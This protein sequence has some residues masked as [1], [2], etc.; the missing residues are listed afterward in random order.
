MAQ[1]HTRNLE[2]YELFRRG[3]SALLTRQRADNEAARDLFRR[4]I[5]IDGAFARAYA[6]LALTHAADFR[7]QWSGDGAASLAPVD[8]AVGWG[9][10]SDTRIVNLIEFSQMGRFFYWRPKEF[11]TVPVTPEILISHGAQMHLIPATKD[12]DGRIRR[13]RPGQIF[14]NDFRHPGKW[15]GS[16]FLQK[17]NGML[18]IDLLDFPL[19]RAGNFPRRFIGNNGDPLLRL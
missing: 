17:E 18:R 19:Q 11:A 1:R 16:V 3:Q 5:A 15:A 7:N 8:L 6:G 14:E 10:L 12:L 2:A 4:A 13:L 9:P